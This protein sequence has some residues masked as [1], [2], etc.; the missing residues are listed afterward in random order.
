[1]IAAYLVMGGICLFYLLL[2]ALAVWAAVVGMARRLRGR[3]EVDETP[4]GEDLST[5][6]L[7]EAIETALAD[8]KVLHRRFRALMKAQKMPLYRRIP[9]LRPRLGAGRRPS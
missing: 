8:R 1:M 3:G 5:A 6:E 7:W 9:G 4:S 2:A